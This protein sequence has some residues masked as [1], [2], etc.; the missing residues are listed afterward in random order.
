[1]VVVLGESSYGLYLIRAPLYEI[2]M[3]AHLHTSRLFFVLYLFGAV[4]LS[5]LSFRYFE[6]P[7]RLAILRRFST[8]SRE[9]L[10]E[11]SISP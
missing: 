6:T 4:L 1:L 11:S 10:V 7:A 9:T 5:V 3:A 2:L 8:R